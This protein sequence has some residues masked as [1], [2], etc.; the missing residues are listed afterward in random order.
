MVNYHISL[1]AKFIFSHRLHHHIQNEALYN[2]KMLRK[3]FALSLLLT[4][5]WKLFTKYD[6]V[7]TIFHS[8]KFLDI[9]KC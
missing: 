1:R 4:L 2:G 9:Y 6:N 5:I 7:N 3:H 8:D